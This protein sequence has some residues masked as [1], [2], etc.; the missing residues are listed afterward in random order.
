[1]SPD[2]KNVSIKT[3]NIAWSS[4]VT[5]KYKNIEQIPEGKSAWEDIQW[6]NMEDPHFMVWMRTAGL[7]NFRKLWGRIDM[8][9][10]PGE[11]Y[12]KVINNY[13]VSPFQG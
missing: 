2:D 4:D 13:E 11:Y 6:L 1:M 10:Q 3:N 12:L 8:T 9:L 5:Y 7:P